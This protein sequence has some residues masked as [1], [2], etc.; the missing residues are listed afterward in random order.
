VAGRGT[1]LLVIDMLNDFVLPGASL[2]VPA[3]RSIVPAI[4]RRIDRAAEDGSPVIYLC[5][6][7]AGDDPE[8]RMWPEHAVKGTTG[9]AVV[10]ELKPRPEDLIVEKSTY[11]A[12]YGTRLEEVLG[13]MGIGRLRITGILTNICVFFTAVEAV[14]RGFEVEVARDSVAALTRDEHDFAL[15]QMARILKAEII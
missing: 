9:A 7:H 8:F 6:A 2:E 13:K 10:D 3:A 12:F 11:S 14:V 4:R 1:A 5:D 15:D